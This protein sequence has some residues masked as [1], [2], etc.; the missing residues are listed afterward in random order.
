MTGVLVLTLVLCYDGSSN[1]PIWTVYSN[2]ESET[3]ALE[4][5]N[6]EQIL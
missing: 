6:I 2:V 5:L 3:G 1:G 4:T